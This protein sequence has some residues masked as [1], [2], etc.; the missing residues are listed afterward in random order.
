MRRLL[1]NCFWL[2]VPLLAVNVIFA[3]DLP[4]AFQPAVFWKDIPRGISLPENVLRG[5]VM[6]LPALMPLRLDTPS[7]RRGLALFVFGNAA[8]FAVWAALILAPASAWSRS[9][10]GFVAPAWTPALWLAGLTLMSDEI[11]VRRIPWRRGVYAALATAFVAF[12]C[13]HTTL[14]WSRVAP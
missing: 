14:V 13:A 6:F 11:V 1:L 12:H 7:R 4:P 9:A 2:L 5:L 3:G 10:I 8:Y